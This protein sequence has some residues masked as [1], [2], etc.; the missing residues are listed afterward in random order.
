MAPPEP[1]D[2]RWLPARPAKGPGGSVC[3]LLNATLQ[4][5]RQLLRTGCDAAVAVVAA[6]MDL[7]NASLRRVVI[8]VS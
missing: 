2:F 4:R 7:L 5:W 1:V 8:R 3:S 6:N